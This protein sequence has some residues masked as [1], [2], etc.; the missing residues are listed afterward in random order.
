MGVQISSGASSQISTSADLANFE[1]V[2]LVRDLARKDKSAALAQL[3]QR[4][5]AAIH[6]GESNSAGDVFGKVKNL[7]SDM[8]D[9]LESEADADATEKAWCDKNLAETRE[10]KA[11]KNAEIEKMST[12]IDRMNAQSSLLK[13]EIA[14]LQAGL[15]KLAS[16]QSQMNKIRAEEHEEYASNKAD[17]EKGLQGVKMGLKVLS[18]YYASEDKD[19]KAATGAGQSIIGLLEVVES[20]FSKNLAEIVSSEE[21][22]V[23]VYEQQTKEN[24]V[25]NTAKTQSVHYKT[26]ESKRLD[27]DS[28]E[29]NSDRSSVQAELDATNEYL[30]K[31]EGRC[32]AK[33]ETHAQRRARYIAEIAGLKEA[34]NILESETALVQTKKAGRS[35]HLRSTRAHIVA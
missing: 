27:K 19:H 28:V 22:A 30:S 24:E 4:M 12:R 7:I 18:E 9:K 10:K 6:A 35:H 16:S 17:M 20:D 26:K 14:E 11:D 25:D 13:E 23:S 31:V 15:A 34:L 21:M 32:I 29:L 3:A 1:A 5:S 33:A 2:R 8:I